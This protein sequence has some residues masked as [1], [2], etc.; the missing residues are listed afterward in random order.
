MKDGWHNDEY[1]ALYENRAEAEAATERYRLANYLPGYLIVGL[2]FWDDFILCDSEDKYYTVP[3]VP[4]VREELRASSF[5]TESL[6]LRADTKLS[7]VT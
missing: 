2:K 3:T 6:K 7:V 5:P 4:L 1:F